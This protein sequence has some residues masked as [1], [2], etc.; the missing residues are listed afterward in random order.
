MKRKLISEIYD[1]EFRVLNPDGREVFVT[2]VR[3]TE[4]TVHKLIKANLDIFTQGN[5]REMKRVTKKE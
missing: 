1:Y 3:V 5:A 4:A 2:R